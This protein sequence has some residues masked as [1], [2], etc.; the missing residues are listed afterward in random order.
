MP[1]LNKVELLGQL[2]R[3]PETHASSSGEMVCSFTIAVTQQVLNLRNEMVNETCYVDIE[4][5]GRIG[6]VVQSYFHK[7]SPVFVDGRLRMEVLT[8]RETGRRRNHLVVVADVI[9]MAESDGSFVPMNVPVMDGEQDVP[10]YS[11]YSEEQGSG[12]PF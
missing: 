3:E 8:D 6:E 10:P 5:P 2:T 9:Q 1:S 12:M 7:D 11:S 4:A